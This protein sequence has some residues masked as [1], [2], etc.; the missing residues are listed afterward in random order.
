MIVCV[1]R[2][3]SESQVEAV[4]TAGAKTVDHVSR[5]CGAGSDCGACRFMV[6]EIVENAR[7]AA[8][9]AGARA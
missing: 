6:A 3:V 5:A 8:C 1:C 7:G 9:P 4:V 2:G